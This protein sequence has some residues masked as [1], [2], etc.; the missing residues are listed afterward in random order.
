MSAPSP[1]CQHAEYLGRKYLPELDGLRALSVLMVVTVHLHEHTW[2]WI[3]GNK[4]VTIFFILSGYLITFLALREESERGTLSLSAF[5]VRRTFRIFPSYYL[6]L[7]VYGFLILVVGVRSDK[8]TNF[9]TALP[10]DLLYLQEIPFEFGVN[11]MHDNL[12]FYH[13]WSLGIEEKFYLV[14]PV[15]AFLALR[16]KKVLR[17]PIALALAAF[18]SVTAAVFGRTVGGCLFSYFHILLGCAVAL[19]LQG[20]PAYRY[21]SVLGQ[22]KFAGLTTVSLLVVHFSWPH[23]G[24]WPYVDTVDVVYSI[25]ASAFLVSVLTGRG[26]LQRILSR[27]PLPLIG[28][29]SYGIYLVHV[30]CLNA[31][32]KALVRLAH[33]HIG[34]SLSI[35][36]LVGAIITSV[37][38]AYLLHRTVEKPLIEIGRRWS[39]RLHGQ[40][41]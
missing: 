13:A 19:V 15:L 34:L 12:P 35:L 26:L 28:R 27:P 30:L 1:P 2:D 14:W 38:V 10:Y 6:V 8:T 41:S 11:G 37:S 4:G 5:Y 25:I 20:E 16:S 18:F 36:K 39:K 21:L 33:G 9:L 7:A 22:R 29:L 24:R 23:F 32:E 17:L 40:T 31:V 3:A